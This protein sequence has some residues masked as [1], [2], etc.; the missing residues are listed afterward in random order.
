MT[1]TTTASQVVCLGN[2]S[3]I[4]FAYAFLIPDAG[5]AVVT[6]T[7][8]S[9]VATVLSPT[10]YA[11]NGIGNPNGGTVQYPLSGSPI[12]DGTTL[13]I[14]RIV[15]L[16]QETEISNQGAFYP[17]SIEQALD[18][19]M[20]CIQQIQT[21]LNNIN[22]INI[23]VAV[24]ECQ[25]A[26]ATA[27]AAATSASADAASAEAA[28]AQAEEIFQSI[29]PASSTLHAVGGSVQSID[30]GQPGLAAS[31]LNLFIDGVKQFTDS[32]A[33]D[34]GGV[35]TPVG[36][37]WPGDGTTINAEVDIN[38]TFHVGVQNIDASQI[39]SG[40]LP[41]GR[42]TGAYPGITGVGTLSE[43]IWEGEPI[44]NAYLNVASAAQFIANAS[45]TILGT[46]ETWEAGEAYPLTD[47][48]TIIVDM[49]LFINAALAS[50][51]ANRT[52]GNPVNTKVGQAG[53][54]KINAGPSTNR[55]LSF[56]SSW[57]V[58]DAGSIVTSIAITA[59]HPVFLFYCVSTSTEIVVSVVRP[60]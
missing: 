28:A 45:N 7:D 49:S 24:Q 20:M 41:P 16:V 22:A 39:T 5:D 58:V 51:A 6:Y 43:G 47:A 40:T 50:M 26:A 29:A 48:P 10:Q 17:E 56:G 55:T 33:V 37:T 52:L 60:L 35:I 34:A 36:G 14:Q 53:Y 54:I 30:T 12:A 23:E 21:Q 42:L 11:I 8:A 19:L 59:A 57:K 9:G 32:Y 31:D 46:T 13:T 3:T 4:L 25:T 15:P 18:Y 44:D 1:I 27:T 2:G 38:T